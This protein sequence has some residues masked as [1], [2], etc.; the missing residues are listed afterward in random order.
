MDDVEFL[1]E[2]SKAEWPS[3]RAELAVEYINSVI[4]AEWG[5]DADSLTGA[6]VIELIKWVIDK[7]EVA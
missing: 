6:E 1:E 7:A 4:D 3:E 2:V 5:R